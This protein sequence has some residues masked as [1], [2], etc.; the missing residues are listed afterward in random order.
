MCMRVTAAQ[1]E[2]NEAR[3]S[4]IHTNTMAN[5]HPNNVYHHVTFFNL[6]IYIYTHIS[7]PFV[8]VGFGE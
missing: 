8:T 6:Y 4:V 7:N 3:I 5:T 2:L 1:S